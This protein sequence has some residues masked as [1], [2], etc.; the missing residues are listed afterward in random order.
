MISFVD[1]CSTTSFSKHIS[2][3]ELRKHEKNW[4]S[5]WK[6]KSFCKQN[7]GST[8]DSKIGPW[9]RFPIS[10]KTLLEIFHDT[11]NLPWYLQDTP[12]KCD[13]CVNCFSSKRN[14]LN[15]IEAVHEG[16]KPFVCANCNAKYSQKHSLILHIARYDHMGCQVF[17]GGTQN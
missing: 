4:K 9:F 8:I 15:H 11:I 16:K 12:F 17:K 14:L 13:Q 1:L 2:H 3:Q 7:F 5:Y 6:K 10:I